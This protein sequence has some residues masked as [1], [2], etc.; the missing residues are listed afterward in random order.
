MKPVNKTPALASSQAPSS[1]SNWSKFRALQLGLCCLILAVLAFSPATQLN[2]TLFRSIEEYQDILLNCLHFP[3]VWVF[4][5]ALRQLLQ[6]RHSIAIT[7]FAILAVELTQFGVGREAS[8]LDI[9]IGLLGLLTASGPTRIIRFL[10]FSGWVL[11]FSILLLFR[12]QIV[13]SFPNMAAFDKAGVRFHWQPIIANESTNS[14]L[15]FFR[16]KQQEKL[17]P[18]RSPS[19]FLRVSKIHNDYWGAR[20]SVKR[21]QAQKQQDLTTLRL[22]GKSQDQLKLLIR[23]DDRKNAQY[24]ERINL[25]IYLTPQLQCYE[26]NLTETMTKLATKGTI[27]DLKNL[28]NIG[29]FAGPSPQD[30][31]ALQRE[32]KT[33]WFEIH[34]LRFQ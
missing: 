19:I 13:S 5:W 3:G 12:S 7:L 4:Y 18:K 10:S 26:L 16:A 32:K 15:L 2:N 28:R 30:E 17:I 23:M 33:E 31:T 21:N 9:V 27:F 29:V 14:S 25:S 22:C 8:M 34:D 6:R 24:H 1:F 11:F 20:A